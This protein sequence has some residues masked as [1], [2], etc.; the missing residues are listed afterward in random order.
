MTAPSAQGF[1]LAGGASERF[2]RDKAR[3]QVDGLPLLTR[4]LRALKG[5]GSEPRVVTPHSDRYSDLALAFVQS[6]RPDRGPVAGVGAALAACGAPWA[7]VLAT[8][9]P[10]VSQKVVRAL[11]ER[12]GEDVD[13]ICLRDL[14]GPTPFPGVYR[15]QTGL[16]VLGERVRSMRDLLGALRVRALDPGE[17]GLAPDV[18]LNT[19]RPEDL[20][21]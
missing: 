13:L 9:M 1:V 3:A 8:D 20:P 10:R 7:V 19:N 21:A 12:T 2:G 6:E 4:S 14:V 15:V 16:A 11:L 5:L 18:L 17:L